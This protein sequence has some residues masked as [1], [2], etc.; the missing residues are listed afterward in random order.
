MVLTN[1]SINA[2]INQLL[3]RN[4]F[5]YS[6]GNNLHS[7]LMRALDE[8]LGSEGDIGRAIGTSARFAGRVG[9]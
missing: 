2:I 1:D 9:G 4:L 6:P 8:V 5:I 7:K 3:N